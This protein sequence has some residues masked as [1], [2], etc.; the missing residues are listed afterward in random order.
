MVKKLL[1]LFILAALFLPAAGIASAQGI[2]AMPEI[3]ATSSTRFDFSLP[4]RQIQDISVSHN[5]Y[6]SRG[7]P[8]N[9]RGWVYE[10]VAKAFTADGSFIQCATNE[11]A[12]VAQDE[13]DRNQHSVR[14]GFCAGLRA[15]TNYTLSVRVYGKSERRSRNTG[16][17]VYVEYPLVQVRTASAS[18]A[19]KPGAISGLRAIAG[20]TDR[21][22]SAIC[23][24]FQRASKAAYYE[25][26]LYVS[27]EGNSNFW[28]GLWHGQDT[29]TCSNHK[30]TDDSTFHIHEEGLLDDTQ[31][32]LQVRAVSADGLVGPTATTR[33]RTKKYAYNPAPFP[34]K[35][36]SSN[37]QAAGNALEVSNITHN[38]FTVSWPNHNR[39]EDYANGASR[40]TSYRARLMTA[41]A[42]I[43]GW[44][45]QSKSYTFTGLD[46]E[47]A[48]VVEIWAIGKDMT[49]ITSSDPMKVTT[50]AAPQSRSSRSSAQSNSQ[51]SPGDQDPNSQGGVS[52]GQGSPQQSEP[53]GSPQQSEPQGSPQQ[54]EPQGSPQQSEPQGSPQQAA[55]T[56]TPVPPP[57][58]TPV[59][60]S[61]SVPNSLIQTVRDYYDDNVAAGRAGKNWLRVLIAF[62]VETDDELTPMTA[63]EARERVSKWG[64]WRPVAEALEQLE[65]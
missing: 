24:V 17:L 58:N 55:P 60:Q 6:P 14:I 15:G 45:T 37:S 8:G 23:A 59:P 21:D 53:Q 47:T 48:Y 63:A 11:P 19:A 50:A 7:R 20:P 61:Y 26:N 35:G 16:H 5:F 56:N 52:A 2:T 44:T 42:F 13:N 27:S 62:G 36:T 18:S 31:Y 39:N 46:P 40:T 9:D 64:G 12:R 54:S 29:S 10:F 4:L 38:R 22:R 28:R 32:V 51:G 65:G 25:I 33:V 30:A 57:P 49:F 34:G 41:E 1:F 43:G 3:T